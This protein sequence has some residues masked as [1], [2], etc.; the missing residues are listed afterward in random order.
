MLSWSADE[1]RTF[2]GITQ[3]HRLYEAWVLLLTRGTRRGEVAGLRW[4]A[5][6]FEGKHL[7][8]TRIRVV[9]KDKTID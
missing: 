3:K 8:I 5:V 9:V 4:D 1:A 2:L 6:D 7:Q